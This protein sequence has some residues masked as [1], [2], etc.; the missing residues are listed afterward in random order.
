M[1]SSLTST[2]MIPRK[3]AFYL[4]KALIV[5]LSLLMKI[6][7]QLLL[8]SVYLFIHAKKDYKSSP[9]QRKVEPWYEDSWNPAILDSCLAS[10]TVMQCTSVLQLCEFVTSKYKWRCA[11]DSACNILYCL[12]KYKTTFL[13]IRSHSFSVCCYTISPGLLILFQ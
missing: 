6:N 11:T 9:K 1:Q 3:V 7:F 12:L 13:F 4:S 5:S 10:W 2:F 8:D